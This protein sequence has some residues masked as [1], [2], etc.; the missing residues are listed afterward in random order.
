[1]ESTPKLV[2][3]R[4]LL[5][6]ILLPFFGLGI[7]QS[8]PT[9]ATDHPFGPTGG[10]ILFWR[11]LSGGNCPGGDNNCNRGSPALADVNN[12]GQ[13][14]IV[15]TTSN[16]RIM[17]IRHDGS[18]DG[19]VIFDVDIAPHIGM[20]AGTAA[21][22]SGVAVADIDEDG[23]V[24]I[25]VGYGS[26]WN[27]NTRGGIIVLEHNG[28]LKSGWP[29]A[30]LGTN[31]NGL[32]HTIFSSPALGDLDNDGDMEIVAGGFDK[33]VYA[34]HHN[35]Q[36]VNGFP[37]DSALLDRF[38]L[39]PNLQGRLAD[40]IWSSPS[41]ADLDGDGFLDIVIGSDEGNFDQR[42]GGDS[43]GWECPYQL[44]PGWAPGYCG[45]SVY[46]FDRNGDVLP[47]FPRYILE[48]VQSTPALVDLDG[49]NRM[50]VVSGTG[51]F[52]WLNSPSTP[53]YGY[54]LSAYR[55][56]G[57]N[58]AGWNPPKNMDSTGP[59]S[60]AVGNIAGDDSPEVVM[61]SHQGTIYAY[62]SNGQ[63][64]SGFPMTPRARTGHTS[65]FD[66]GYGVILADY[67]N[68][69]R[70][71]IFVPQRE[72]IT[73][74]DGNGNQLTTSNNGNDGKPTY[75]TG[76][77]LRNSPAVGDVDGDG[78]LELI[79]HD[80]RLYVYDL[81]NAGSQA[82]WGM[83]KRDAAGTGRGDR[84]GTMSPISG[85]LNIFRAP[86]NSNFGYSGLGI[87]NLGDL[88]ISFNVNESSANSRVNVVNNS[89]TVA[90]G[91]VASIRVE[92]NNINSLSSGWNNL[93]SIHVS[94]TNSAGST[95]GSQ[96]VA[97]WVYKGAVNY[98]FMPIGTSN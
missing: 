66:V 60:P 8:I 46:A 10:D 38:P 26:E 16:G 87:A 31:A 80:S 64:V 45:G 30:S 44:P 88:P 18:A 5:F 20:S 27:H 12:D 4:L 81:P 42:Y 3:S 53:T 75:A 48:T 56:N 86:N 96:A 7:S 55:H 41:L 69:G 21:I 43:G 62:H 98:Q 91:E 84:L 32:P 89:G 23:R 9:N 17:A 28:S 68:D 65:I 19:A 14:D 35:G 15:L 51:S 95:A 1:M 83:F 39:W 58:V 85:E 76:G 61:M 11:Q 72:S 34:Y 59:G 70:Q 6:L 94:A 29:K 67:D 78:K 37:A 77:W 24:E 33:R 92:V 13:L 63:L 79:V 36:L 25:A 50:D 73:V 74:V 22:A 97:I 93:G 82:E 2:S 71:E 54:I 40:S 90:G 57:G 52:Y 47:G 49:D